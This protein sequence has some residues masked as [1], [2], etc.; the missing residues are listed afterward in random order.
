MA[1]RSGRGR[2]VVQVVVIP[3]LGAALMGEAV[4]DEAQPHEPLVIFTQSFVSIGSPVTTGAATFDAD[5]GGLLAG[6]TLARVS[7]FGD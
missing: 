1:H 5:R 7:G 6:W 2:R 3:V 4:G